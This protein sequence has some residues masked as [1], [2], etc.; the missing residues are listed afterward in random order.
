MPYRDTPQTLAQKM[1][2][3]SER[4]RDRNSVK[5]EKHAFPSVIAGIESRADK[6]HKEA[7]LSM[8]LEEFNKSYLVDNRRLKRLLEENGFTVDGDR[9]SWG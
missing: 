5:T 3:R 6:G 2:E 9:I 1:S 4:G 7:S 8:L